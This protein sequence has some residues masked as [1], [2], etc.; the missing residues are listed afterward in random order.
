MTSTLYHSVGSLSIRWLFSSDLYRS[1][2]EV[3]DDG[4]GSPDP[5]PDL[6]DGG[7]EGAGGR[8]LAPLPALR[9]VLVHVLGEVPGIDRYA[10]RVYRIIDY[11]W[12][13]R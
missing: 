5:A 6:G 7:R 9:Q 13:D 11:R 8:L 2:G 1:V 12:I 10:Y 4:L 3:H